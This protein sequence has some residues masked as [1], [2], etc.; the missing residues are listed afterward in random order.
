MFSQIHS[1]KYVLH[2]S[3][4][5]IL[6]TKKPFFKKSANI[7]NVKYEGMNEVKPF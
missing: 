4:F 3:S 6:E 7:S 1:H 5:N 2:D